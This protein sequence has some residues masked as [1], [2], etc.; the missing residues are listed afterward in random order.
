MGFWQ[1]I[2]AG[3][4]AVQEEKSR[5][6]EIEEQRQYEREMF[7]LKTA[8]SRRD[9]LFTLFA[10]RQRDDAQAKALT[11][12]AQNFFS[13][14]GEVDDP[15]VAALAR[16]PQ[17]AAALEKEIRSLEIDARKN[18]VEP[19][20]LRGQE[21]LDLLTVYNP[22]TGDIKPVSVSIEDISDMDL[23]D[24]SNYEKLALE[25]TQPVVRPT[26]TLS[27]EAYRRFDPKVLEKG[28]EVFDQEVLRLA[29]EALK[30]TDA[31]GDSE[32]RPLIENYGEE[33][34][35]ERF[36]L[37][38][39]F[40][41]QAFANLAAMDNPYIQDFERDPILSR[42]AL[43]KISTEEEYNELPPGTMY[44]HPDGKVKRKS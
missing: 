26:A 6:R 18:G 38:D 16:N 19:P 9:S 27:T 22:N 8:E 43:P 35:A 29:N 4:A 11:S 28:N 21:L 34:S 12:D 37:M 25:L 20:V 7:M 32:L 13:R 30:G 44:V 10:E 5:K 17:A 40:G 42:Y 15:R 2:N 36:A 31:T 3:L 41:H 14:L 39:M 23:S 33:G 1:G 24:R